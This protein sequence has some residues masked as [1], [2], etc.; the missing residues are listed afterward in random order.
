MNKN[1]KIRIKEK[2][3][4]WFKFKSVSRNNTGDRTELQEQYRA[5]SK[6]MKTDIRRELI[7]LKSN[8]AKK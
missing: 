6:E 5:V 3:R 2:H 4:P 8:L 1:L 7:E